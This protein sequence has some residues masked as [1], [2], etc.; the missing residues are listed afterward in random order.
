MGKKLLSLLMIPLLALSACGPEDGAARQTAAEA[1]RQVR[2]AFLAAGSLDGTVEVTADYGLRVYEFTLAFAWQRG[3]ETTL[4][5]MEPEELAGLTARIAEGDTRLEFDG[6]SLSTGP[7]DGE[8][9]TPMELLP[10]VMAYA[11]EG[12]MAQCAFEQ[13]DGTEVL[14][15]AYRDP[16]K[17]AGTGAEC[18]QWF[19]RDSG[20]L[21]RAELSWDGELVLS[22]N[23]TEFHLGGTEDDGYGQDTDLGGDQPGEPGA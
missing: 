12:Y 20:A 1:A 8:G 6:I 3:G 17:A 21:L 23:F 18:V 11:Q 22:G 19:R 13:L 5:V 15:I 10:G 2:A 14:R 16:D 9:L 4:T 7:L